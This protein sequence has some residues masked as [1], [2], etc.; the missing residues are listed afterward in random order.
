MKTMY[1]IYSNNLCRPVKQNELKY[2][3]DDMDIIDIVMEESQNDCLEE[4]HSDVR[5]AK[6]K[7]YEYEKKSS[8]FIDNEGN[9][10]AIIYW[11][12]EVTFDEIKGSV[13]ECEGTWLI[14]GEGLA[15][16]NEE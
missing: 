1:A 13:V 2:G 8:T 7:F 14:T 9:L 15:P 3:I 12:E 4:L 6:Q 16:N 11:L 5:I 10:N